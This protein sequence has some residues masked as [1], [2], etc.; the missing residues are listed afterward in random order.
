MSKLFSL[1]LIFILSLV[2]LSGCVSENEGNE[3]SKFRI[4]NVTWV[5]FAPLYL[6]EEKGFFDEQGID[7]E[8]EMIEDS[9]LRR[10]AL[11]SKRVDAIVDA[12]DVLVIERAQGIKG[13]AVT[14]LD[15]SAGGD[16]IITVDSINSVQ[17]F[18]GKEIA[19]QIDTPSESMLLYLLKKNGLT[20]NDVKI[21]PMEAGA[22][23]AA[24]VSG[25]VDIAVTWEPWLSKASE[26]G[27][28][29]VFVS[30]REEKGLI[31]DLLTVHEDVLSSRPEDV[32]KVLRAWFKAI[33]FWKKNPAEA[34][35]IMAKYYDL[36][37]EEFAEIIS[38]VEWLSLSETREFFGN[39][40]SESKV[41]DVA[42]TF[43]DIF[44]EAEKID[45]PV[46]AGEL[47]E[48]DLLFGLE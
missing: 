22:A 25:Q 21:L 5:G 1:I 7:I 37:S 35:E 46:S 47:F 14:V 20:A 16:G 38:G 10:A 33:D 17:D 9:A 8:I 12:V 11:A 26:R 13:K 42:E 28:G 39:D 29:K 6:A 34:N 31:V 24:F 18:K 30:T 48:L 40:L 45:R 19:V 32:K 15:L 2:L 41:A 27:N 43:S 23:G 4:G 3:K 36:P 44:L